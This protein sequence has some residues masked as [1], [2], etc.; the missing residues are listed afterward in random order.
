MLMLLT[1]TYLLSYLIT[2]LLLV[3]RDFQT[4]RTIGTLISVY[5]Y[6]SR[7]QVINTACYC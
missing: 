4:V 5:R 7:T 1:Y 3:S 6:S 2:G